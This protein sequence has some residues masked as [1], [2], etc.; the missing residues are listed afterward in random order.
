MSYEFSNGFKIRNQSAPHFLTFTIEGW[1]DIFSRKV[2]RDIIIDSMQFCRLNK[3]LKVHAYV[4]M[5]NHVHTIWTAEQ[6]N[7]SDIIR[8]FKTHT[9]KQF[10]AYIQENGCESRNEWLLYM[11]K[12]YANR[13]ARN[14]IFKV[15]KGNSHPEE[16]HL[17]DFFEQKL[18][19]IHGNPVRAGIV[20]EQ[21]HYL[22]SSAQ[23]YQ[24]NSGLMEIDYLV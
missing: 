22:Y 17:K 6:N 2:Y 24:L 8:D 9:S 7:L 15:W 5:S 10:T 23:F 19:Y 1:I 14:K 11:F 4:V 18:H 3:S 12:F 20:A 21:S 16:I 13:T